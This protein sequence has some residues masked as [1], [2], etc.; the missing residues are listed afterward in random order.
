MNRKIC[1]V[2]GTRAEYGLLHD[3]MKG[4][5]ACPGLDLQV[6]ATGT[7][8]SPEFG[9][10]H[11]D[12]EK[13][14]IHIDKKVEMLL[15]S[16]TPTSITKSIGL[17][18]I[19]FSDALEEL[20][21]DIL[22]ILGDRYELVS[23]AYAALIARIPIAHLHGGETTEGAFDEAIRH[24]ITKLAYLHFTGAEDYSRR[25]V[26]L[27]EHPNRVFHVGGIGVDVIKHIKM[28]SKD[29]L[30]DRIGFKFK[31]R[32]L[33]FTFHP[34]TLE[35]GTAEEQ[36]AELLAALVDLKDTG[37]IFTAPNA[38]TDGRI[39]STKINAFVQDHTDC[40]IQFVSMG[41]VPYL[42][43]LQ[44]VD[45]VVGNS[46]SGLAEA[47][48][49]KIGTINIGD[50]QKGRLSSTSVIDCQSDRKS[51]CIALEKLYSSEFKTAL[52]HAKNPYG[53]GDA[54]EKII[55]VLRKFDLPKNPKK[56]FYDLP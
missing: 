45:A 20:Q 50:R 56:S 4:V 15:S 13:D 47:P 31:N 42:S 26:Q 11:R 2:T 48:T 6:I 24:S 39:I 33:L 38:D 10:T 1:I 16:D 44:Y 54:C 34:V 7:H 40:A 25:V 22:L 5:Q 51:I 37:F 8:M 17:G 27:G 29:E 55:E 30:E 35:E 36:I 43:C 23:A 53:E 14:G 49:F 28:L 12:I 32:N 52:A 3:L 18:L 46:S 19:G 21:P 41:Q 9:L